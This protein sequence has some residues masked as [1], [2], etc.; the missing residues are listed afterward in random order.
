M[1]R[2]QETYRRLFRMAHNLGPNGQL[3]TFAELRGDLGVSVATLNRALELLETHRVVYRRHGVGIFVCSNL[4]QRN[5]A[6]VCRPRF[7]EGPEISPFWQILIDH[8]RRVVTERQYGFSMHFGTADGA[9]FGLQEDLKRLVEERRVQGVVGLGLGREAG[10]WLRDAGVPAVGFAGEMPFR[11]VVDY[12]RIV[13]EGLDYLA[14]RGCRRIAIVTPLESFDRVQEFFDP[15]RIAAFRLRGVDVTVI[16]T[17]A[18]VGRSEGNDRPY[19][20]PLWEQGYRVV[21]TIFGPKNGGN[22]PDGI[23]S[24]SELFSQGMLIGLQRNGITVGEQVHLVTHANEG[25]SVL[26]PWVGEIVRFLVSPAELAVT[27]LEM[28]ETLFAGEVPEPATRIHVAE[29]VPDGGAV[30]I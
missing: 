26:L 17:A 2:T 3:P 22:A 15:D 21:Q 24:T 29:R 18:A 19:P 1:T 20:L 11:V 9:E 30:R 14:D 4:G 27:M 12:P 25:A 23:V 7:F 16:D 28:L 10:D 6:V 5:I 8:L 13:R